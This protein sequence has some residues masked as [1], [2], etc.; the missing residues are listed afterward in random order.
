MK[1][2][3]EKYMLNEKLFFSGRISQVRYCAH[4]LNLMVQDGSSVIRKFIENIQGN[5]KYFKISPSRLD[6]FIEVVKQLKLPTSKRLIL[7][8]LTRWNST[9]AMLDAALVLKD[10][11]PRYKSH[12]PNYKWLPSMEDWRKAERICKFL[13]VFNEATNVFSGTRYPTSNL[14]LPEN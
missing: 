6:K 10:T 12:D 2:L 1:C 14:F 4:I 11:F 13:K 8:V 9:Y 3:I 5:V 7:D